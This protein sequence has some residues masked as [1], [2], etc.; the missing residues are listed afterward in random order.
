[1]GGRYLLDTNIIIDTFKDNK[2]LAAKI[3]EAEEV[4]VPVITL[5]ELYY[6]A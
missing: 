2:S 3:D 6:G 4:F 5:G 1:M